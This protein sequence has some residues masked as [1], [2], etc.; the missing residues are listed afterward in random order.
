MSNSFK[1]GDQVTF[2]V[3][4]LGLKQA[5]TVTKTGTIKEI[6]GDVCCVELDNGVTQVV[7]V[8]ELTQGEG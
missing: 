2:S 5:K 8:S 6:I 4:V 3:K 7:K 1:T